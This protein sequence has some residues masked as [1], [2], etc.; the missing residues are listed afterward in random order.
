MDYESEAL[1]FYPE[2]PLDNIKNL[3]LYLKSELSQNNNNARSNY[4]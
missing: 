4:N 3:S 2:N 1:V